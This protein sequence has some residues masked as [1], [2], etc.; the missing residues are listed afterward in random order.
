VAP[1]AHTRTPMP[2]T[3]TPIPYTPIGG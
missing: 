3:R 2:H 1:F